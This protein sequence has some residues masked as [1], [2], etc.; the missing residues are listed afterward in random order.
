M[1]Q[2]KV[3]SAQM[4]YVRYARQI[5]RFMT[6]IVIGLSIPSIWTTRARR[7]FFIGFS[8]KLCIVYQIR[9]PYASVF[10]TV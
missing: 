6:T 9:P 1:P 10:K 8:I 7:C 4:L 2:I 5:H 3:Q